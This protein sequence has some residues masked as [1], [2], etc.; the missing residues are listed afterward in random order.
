MKK[1]SCCKQHKPLSDFTKSKSNKDG[2]G[3][4]CFP[5]RKD[6]KKAEYLRNRDKYLARSEKQRKENPENVSEI[7]KQCYLKKLDQ[8]KQKQ[9]RYYEENRDAVLA[10]ARRYRETNKKLIRERDNAYKARNRSILNKKQSEY[11]KINAEKLNEYRRKYTK[12][13]RA[14]DR[15]FAIR[16]NMRTRFKFELAKRGEIKSIKANRYLGC[17]WVFL[18]DYLAGK[19]VD[20]MSWDNYGE[21]HVDHIIPLASAQTKDE[22]IKLC[23]YSNLQPL[24]AFDN[25]SKGAKMPDIAA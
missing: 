25:L 12:Q 24:W 22:L 14:K 21:W 11:Q 3:I 13:R 1:C 9:R 8:Y 10:Q 15:M 2:F 19:F 4:Y 18:K 17:T 7:K 6:K 20:G 23:H 5:C 16:L